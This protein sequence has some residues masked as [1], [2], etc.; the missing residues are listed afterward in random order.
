MSREQFDRRELV[1]YLPVKLL[2]TRMTTEV[3]M[4]ALMNETQVSEMLQVSLAC[5]R[6]W[7]LLGEGPEYK[8]VGPLVRYRPE[9]VADWVNRQPSGG[10]GQRFEPRRQRMLGPSS[11]RRPGLQTG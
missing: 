9:S 8:K 2:L 1:G 7:R 10:N 11:A 3:L 4:E 5:L 6:R